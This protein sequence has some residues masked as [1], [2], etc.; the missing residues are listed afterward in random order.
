M[1]RN[2]ARWFGACA[3]GLALAAGMGGQPAHAVM[4]AATA[5]GNTTAP[6][7]D[8]GFA[9]VAKKAFTTGVYVG[10]GWVLTCNHVG[11]AAIEIHIDRDGDG[12]IETETYQPVAGSDVRLHNPA[13]LSE[14]TDLKLYRLATSPR[15]PTLRISETSVPRNALVYL[16][17]YGRDRDE[18]LTAWTSSWTE[19]D[20][21]GVYRG[22]KALTT[23]T[24][25]W[26]T[27]QVQGS[28][29]ILKL[30]T[31]EGIIDV[32]SLYTTFTE[33]GLA[34]AFECQASG[35]DSGGGLF[36]KRNG[37]WELGGILHAI[38][39]NEGQPGNS[40]VFGNLTYTSDL[41]YYRNEI[42]SIIT[43]TPGDANF[44][45]VVNE[46]DAAILARNWL[47]SS[48]AI[49]EDGDF[50]GDGRVD[51]LD[52]SVLAAN[53]HFGGGGGVATPEPATLASLLG[54]VVTLLAW[55]AFRRR[56]R[57]RRDSRP[58]GACP[59]RLR[60]GA[61]SRSLLWRG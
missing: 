3:L 28:P 37:Q 24:V 15:L 46:V 57:G 11:S 56:R 33:G 47:M 45:Q 29:T 5:T 58:V 44:D 22:Y 8:F 32:I 59:L 42:L 23:Q 54:A 48:G 38:G 20:P 25:R 30:S 26:G 60:R 12:V 13:G 17:G 18:N 53:W 36:Y 51:D 43:P 9:H 1:V 10:W 55:R 4:V 14:Y 49:W 16:A 21:P 50:T 7:D 34:T 61:G 31:G 39:P 19:T 27:N 52:A 35:G 41:S 40:A 2:T 6:A